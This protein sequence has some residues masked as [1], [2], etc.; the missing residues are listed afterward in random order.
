[1]A[2]ADGAGSAQVLLVRTDAK[3]GRFDV[4]AAYENEGRQLSLSLL[5]EEGEN[6]IAA[7]LLNIP[8][9]PALRLEVQGDAPLDDFAAQIA[10]AT[11]GTD[12]VTGT[13]QLS[14]PSGGVDQAFNVDLSGDLRPLMAAQYH[15]FFGAR[16]VLRAE[17]KAFGVGGVRL[18]TLTLAADQL[19]LRGSGE[20]DA[21]GWPVALDL[22]GRLGSGNADRV[23]L[24]IGGTPT[25]VSGMSLNVQY[26]A[27]TGDAWTAA[28]DITSLVREGIA[29]DALALSGDGTLI[30]GAGASDGV[31]SADLSYAARG[32]GFDDDALGQAVGR[33]IEGTLDLARREGD[34]LTINALTLRGAGIQVRGDAVIAG[35]SE[36]F[37]TRA[38]L[39]I[40]AADF[41]RFAGLSGLDLAGAGAINVSATTVPLDGT[42]N[43]ALTAG[44]TDLGF[45]IEQVDPLHEH[46]EFM[47]SIR[48]LA[49]Y[50]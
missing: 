16:T 11:N 4:D 41:S 21:R 23:R 25:E 50:M 39:D 40:E 20:V 14:R 46:C 38:N 2:L 42:F 30:P 22:R 13:V 35:P 15:P 47:V 34:P 49:R 32:L 8:D 44:T 12:R 9:R 31:F 36:R 1:L 18:S 28:F 6:G 17:G 26:D 48:T 37:E 43:I 45:G 10:L 33:D 27:D 7:R 19:V 3:T 24:P 5:A 29:I